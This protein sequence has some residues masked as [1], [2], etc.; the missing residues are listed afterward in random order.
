V[1]VSKTNF[2]EPASGH[3]FTIVNDEEFDCGVVSGIC[4]SEVTAEE[5]VSASASLEEKTERAEAREMVRT[6]LAEGP[7]ATADLLKLTRKSGLSDTTVKRARHDLEVRST[8]RRDPTSGRVVGWELELPT[9]SATPC[10]LTDSAFD[11]VDP[12]DPV[13]GIRGGSMTRPG[14]PEDPEGQSANWEEPP[15]DDSLFLDDESDPWD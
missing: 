4:G 7:M 15:P 3:A 1:R 8:Q 13:D 9:G 6:L 12:V 11:P 10:R 2:R 5:L 14:G